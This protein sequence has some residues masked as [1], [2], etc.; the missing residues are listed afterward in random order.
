MKELFEEFFQIGN[1]PL[2]LSKSA[3]AEDSQL[4]C[5][6]G[7]RAA[8]D[9]SLVLREQIICNCSKSFSLRVS[10]FQIRT[11][12]KVGMSNLREQERYWTTID[13]RQSC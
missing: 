12:S 2:R 9:T 8:D 5:Q 11:P 3:A 10:K 7:Y 1:A 6:N 13:L 4:K